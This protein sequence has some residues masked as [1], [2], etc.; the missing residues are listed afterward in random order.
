MKVMYCLHQLLFLIFYI[1]YYNK[2]YKTRRLK[3][4]EPGKL[5]ASWLSCI[6]YCTYTICNS[7]KKLK[8]T[9]PIILNTGGVAI[10]KYGNIQ[11]FAR[12]HGNILAR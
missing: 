12:E 1:T 8:E 6:I 5:E 4:E 2:Q 3:L 9:V 10:I 7:G 11:K